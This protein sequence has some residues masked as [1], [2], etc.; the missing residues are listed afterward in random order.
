MAAKKIISVGLK[1]L[2]YADVASTGVPTTWTDIEVVHEDTFDYSVEAGTEEQYIN[3]LDGQPYHVDGQNGTPLMNF[4]IGKYDLEMKAAFFGGTYAQATASENESWTPSDTGE[5][6][7]KAFRAVTKDGV[8]IV[9]PKARINPSHTR[10][11][12]ALGLTLQA[13]PI[14]LDTD[15]PLEKWEVDGTKTA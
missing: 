11:I 1:T 2:E 10:N 7:Y 6:V 4:S 15:T 13:R 9:F 12:K 5:S 14:K 3:E 8:V